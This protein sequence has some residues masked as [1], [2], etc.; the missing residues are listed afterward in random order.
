MNS[1]FVVFTIILS[2]AGWFLFAVTAVF[3]GLIALEYI[4]DH[5]P[6][7]VGRAADD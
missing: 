3:F 2:I 6:H 5:R 7:V 1:V 4:C